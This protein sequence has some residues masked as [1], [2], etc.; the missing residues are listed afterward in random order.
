MLAQ[1]WVQSA[2]TV[3]EQAAGA[4]AARNSRRH[5]RRPAGAPAR[6]AHSVG[7]DLSTEGGRQSRRLSPL[8]FQPNPFLHPLWHPL[9]LLTLLSASPTLGPLP[10]PGPVLGSHPPGPAPPGSPRWLRSR[11]WLSLS[12]SLSKR[13]PK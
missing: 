12:L 10:S 7:Q 5:P 1:E 11:L 2:Q 3:P 6:N 4:E 8:F 13:S 9:C